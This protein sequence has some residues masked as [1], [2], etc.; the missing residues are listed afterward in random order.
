[1]HRQSCPSPRD[2]NGG[3]RAWSR[4]HHYTT[5]G[6]SAPRESLSCRQFQAT[7]VRHSSVIQVQEDL[8]SSSDRRKW[9][10]FQI[11]DENSSASNALLASSSI[12]LSEELQ[13]SATRGLNTPGE[14][15][16]PWQQVVAT[17]LEQ[18]SALLRKLAAAAAGGLPP[19]QGSAAALTASDCTTR[20]SS[21]SAS[22]LPRRKWRNRRNRQRKKLRKLF[23]AAGLLS[24]SGV[25]VSNCT[26]ADGSSAL[27]VSQDSSRSPASRLQ[28]SVSS[29]VRL[30]A[31]ACSTVVDAN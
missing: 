9:P 21:G 5:C 30:E 7:T 11:A 4:R 18:Q 15:A 17:L 20:N 3:R 6:V 29:F 2:T 31:Y 16:G 27:E 19:P 22:L 23:T 8:G 25:E 28:S 14:G 12:G 10:E 26:A 1:M 13:Q 24:K